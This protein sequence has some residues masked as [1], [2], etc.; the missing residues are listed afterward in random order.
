MGRGDGMN[1]AL[2]L[3]NSNICSPLIEVPGS[4]R[5]ARGIPPGTVCDV[6]GIYN[7]KVPDDNESKVWA[8]DMRSAED[9][10]EVP[11]PAIR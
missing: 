11:V 10:C 7:S 3:S 8:R 9:S 1:L 2:R 5:G 6:C 4:I